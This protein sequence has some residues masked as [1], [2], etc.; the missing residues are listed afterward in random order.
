MCL[1]YRVS[2]FTILPFFSRL[3][4]SIQAKLGKTQPVLHKHAASREPCCRGGKNLISVTLLP[5][6]LRFRIFSASVN[7]ENFKVHSAQTPE[8]HKHYLNMSVYLL[9]TENPPLRLRTKRNFRLSSADSAPY[10][11][12]LRFVVS[13]TVM[14][15]KGLRM[16]LHE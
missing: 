9:K 12:Q 5:F 13:S 14:A 4:S 10:S 6:Q 8:N 3:P 11:P 15:S 1:P 16:R 2:I 7:F